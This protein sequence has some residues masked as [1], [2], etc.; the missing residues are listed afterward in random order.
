MTKKIYEL[1]IYLLSFGI[2]F[3]FGWFVLH[4]LLR[5]F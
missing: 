3:A 2:G 1:T 5:L 4:L